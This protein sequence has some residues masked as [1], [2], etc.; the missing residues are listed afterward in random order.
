MAALTFKGKP[1]VQNYHLTV[2]YH[3]LVP[4]KAKSL[5]DKV[6][7]DDNLI[8]HGD[9]LK[10]LKALLPT[11]AGKVK[12]IYIDPPY[13]TGNENWAYNDN[14]NSPMMQE[15]LGKV[16]DREDLTRHD[17]WLCMMMPRLK[18]LKELLGEDGVIC[19]SIDD[20]EL[21]HL[22]TM[23]DEIFGEENKEEIVCWRRRHNQPNDKSKAISKVAEFI[24]IYAKNLQYLKK[25]KAFHGLPLTGQFANPDDD[26]KGPWASKPWK[27]GTGQTGTRYKIITPTGKV[28]DEE[29]R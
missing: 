21:A 4:K 3:E 27:A 11:Y 24:V 2:K 23:M 13:N 19:I 7:L 17:K 15:W 8:I 28:L 1:F 25:H 12:C 26:L 6:R 22:V 29:W 18:L 10:A 5:T 16:V 9:N 20:T 14:V